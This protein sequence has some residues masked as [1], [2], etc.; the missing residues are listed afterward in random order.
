MKKKIILFIFALIL[1]MGLT[2][3]FDIQHFLLGIV[4]SVVVS[5]LTGDMF[6]NRPYVFGHPKRYLWFLYYAV[7]FVW[8]CLKANIDVMYRV[9]HPSIPI[10]PGIIKIKTKLKSDTGI[11]FLANSITLTPGTLSVDIDRENGIL[12][13]HWINVKATDIETATK[14]I[15]GVFESI[16]ERIFE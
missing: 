12:Y 3:P 11:T 4:V 14:K 7:I 13:I 6:I 16:L 2:W 10:K 1:W 15:A 8:E 9:A 5:L